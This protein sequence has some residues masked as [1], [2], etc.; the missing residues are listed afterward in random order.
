MPKC[1]S[2]SLAR[3]GI[4]C[5]LTQSK[6][7]GS[8]ADYPT[9]SIPS[10]GW[11]G[12]QLTKLCLPSSLTGTSIFPPKPSGLGVSIINQKNNMSALQVGLRRFAKGFLAGGLAQVVLIINAGFTIHNIADLNAILTAVL[13]GFLTGGLLAIQKMLTYKE[14]P[15]SSYP[16]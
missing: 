10:F 5:I 6:R 1:G 3:K 7:L 12:V 11:G 16:V 4:D 13:T 9:Q 2:V 8:L 14:E 15:P